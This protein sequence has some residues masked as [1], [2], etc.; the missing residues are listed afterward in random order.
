M[1][2]KKVFILAAAFGLLWLLFRSTGCQSRRKTA[3]SG[4]LPPAVLS[5]M[6]YNVENLFDTLDDPRTDDEEFLPDS[7]KR[8]NAAR[9][10]TKIKALA[11][12]IAD[13]GPPVLVGLVEV[14]NDRVLNDLAGALRRL[15]ERDFE[16]VHYDSRYHRGVD[17]ALLYNAD[18]V[19]LLESHPIPVEKPGDFVSRDILHA[20]VKVRRGALSDTFDVFVNHW[21]SRR[22]G[23]AQSEYRRVVAARALSEAVQQVMQQNPHAEVIIMGDFNDEPDD[24]SI[25][26][27]LGAGP[28]KAHTPLVSL[29]WAAVRKGEGTYRYKSAWDILDHFIVSRQVLEPEGFYVAEPRARIFKEDRLLEQDERYGGERPN[30]TYY[31]PR[32]HGGVS[33]HL[34]IV[35]RLVP[36][37]TNKAR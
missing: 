9:Y 15:T 24:R 5:I 30:R 8:W 7:D 14:E 10:H 33:D 20:R 17:V 21:P 32:Y 19:T 35:L 34:P 12:V 22:S 25:Q 11:Q 26:Q 29:M 1:N 16:I 4:T 6:S 36:A 37:G 3:S 18:V 27:V 13:A 23:K 2:I 31:G 28:P